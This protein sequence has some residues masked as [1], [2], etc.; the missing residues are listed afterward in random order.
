MRTGRRRP[1]A[2][3]TYLLLLFAMA[4]GGIGLAAL[5]EQARQRALREQEAELRF[6]GE[7]IARAIASYVDAG[8]VGSRPLPR[9]VDDLLEDRRSGRPVRH[10]RQLRSDP[11]GG[12]WVWLAP[13]EA[14]CTGAAPR[15]PRAPGLVGVRSGSTRLLLRNAGDKPVMACDLTF[16][17]RSVGR[18]TRAGP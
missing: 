1:Q 18:P 8:P 6:R 5:G 2:G 16:D 10:L 7:E 4:I 3:F 17:H 15:M 13:G 11:L 12:G 14:G 9:T